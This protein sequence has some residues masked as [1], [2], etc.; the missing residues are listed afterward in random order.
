MKIV[1][2]R[3]VMMSLV[4]LE[5]DDVLFGGVVVLHQRNRSV[6]TNAIQGNFLKYRL[7]SKLMTHV[8]KK[9]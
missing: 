7:F 3:K 5:R 4:G 9:I 2:T 6:K 8:F 1:L